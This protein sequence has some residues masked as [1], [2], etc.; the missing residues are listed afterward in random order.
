MSGE[1]RLKEAIGGGGLYSSPILYPLSYG[2]GRNCPLYTDNILARPPIAVP[3]VPSHWYFQHNVAK[4][5][6]LPS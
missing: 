1:L 2:R 4:N 3:R 5:P 6:F